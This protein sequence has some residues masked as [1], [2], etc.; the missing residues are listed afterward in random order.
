MTNLYLNNLKSPNYVGNIDSTETFRTPSLYKFLP[1]DN[2]SDRN[3]YI[4]GSVKYGG[5]DKVFSEPTG[6][7]VLDNR[8]SELNQQYKFYYT[9]S[10]QYAQ[11]QL[12]SLDRYVNFYSSK[13]LVETDLDPG[14]QD[15]TALN[16]SFYEGVKNTISTTTDGDYPIVI[17]V[18]SP[19]VAVP[20][21]ST[22]TNL[23]IIDSE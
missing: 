15:I 2:F 7:I 18:T 17:R 12:T 6:S 10:A 3:L 11:S 23:N 16:N 5:P 9:S 21:D 20:T 19:T 14:Y 1:N 13:S 8:K 4:S 22:D